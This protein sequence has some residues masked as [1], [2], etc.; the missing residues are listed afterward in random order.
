MDCASS[1]SVYRLVTVHSSYFSPFL[2]DVHVM[3]WSRAT[4][5]RVVRPRF[6]LCRDSA[7]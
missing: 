1:G 7:Q 6:A 2:F 3:F 4:R 5:E